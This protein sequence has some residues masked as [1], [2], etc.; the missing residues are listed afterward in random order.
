MFA[1]K[2][3]KVQS[4]ASES[5]ASKLAHQHSTIAARAFGG[6]AIEQAQIGNQ[7]SLRRSSQQGF[8]PTEKKVGGDH[9][10]E[11]T[12]A[13]MTAQVA[14]PGVSW[15]FSK[16][17]VFPPDRASRP[18]PSSPFAA[19]PLLG[20]T[21]ARLAVG[22]VNDP[23]EHEADR[24]ADQVMRMPAPDISVTSTPPNL[25]RK[26]TAGVVQD[27]LRSPG[28][29]LDTSTRAFF[30]PRF[31]HDFS[32]VRVHA[33]AKGA[34][35]AGDAG[36]RAYTLGERIVFGPSQFAPHNATGQHLLAHELAHVVQQR[37]AGAAWVQRAPL[38]YGNTAVTVQPPPKPFTLQDAKNLIQQ[39]MNTT[40]PALTKA[41]VKGATPGSDAEIFLWFIL[42]QVATPA[43]WGTENDLIE[44]IGWPPAPA[45]AT[46]GLPAPGGQGTTTTP[47][48]GGSA[49]TPAASAPV[50]AVTVR[51]DQAGA[52]VAELISTKP[53]GPAKTYAKP[54]DGKADLVAAYG[55]KSVADGDAAWTADELNRVAGAFAVL[56]AADKAAL[57]DVDLKRVQVIDA[58]HAAQF[59]DQT[60]AVT[61]T[62]TVASQ[63]NT[64][65]VGNAAFAGESTRFV[66]DASQPLPSSYQLLV[67]EVGHAIASKV[68]RDADLA[69]AQA[70]V[71][72]NLLVQPVTDAGAAVTAAAHELNGLIDAFNATIPKL[73]AAR[74]VKDD[75]TIKTILDDQSARRM[76]IDA[77]RKA[78]E[79]LRKDEQT[80]TA[81][82]TTAKA[83]QQK[84]KTA[85]AATRVSPQA[86]A[87]A[88]STATARGAAAKSALSRAQ[89]GVKQFNSQD[90]TDSD[91]FRSAVAAMS[92]QID[93]YVGN[94]NAGGVDAD[95]E[96]ASLSSATDARNQARD[97]L[98]AAA[99]A[100]PALAV[101]APVLTAQDA[102]AESVKTWARIAD[103]T[104]RVQRFVDMVNKNHIEPF[105][106][107][108]RDNWPFN[109]DEFYAEAYSLWRTDPEYLKANAK[110]VFDWFD[111]KNYLK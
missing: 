41:D 61:A 64:L 93:S 30:E 3:A 21:Q 110:P 20:A 38:T 50:A 82:L 37:S 76:V 1:P 59:G 10:Q 86:V 48:S 83:E 103:R 60:A 63:T 22:Q 40:P 6:G 42:A 29:P 44:P 9:E 107:Y 81:T 73:A 66:G 74:K 53:I 5:P 28:Q 104:M 19:T 75:A 100:N 12:P 80:K 99:A 45:S 25:R 67:H 14:T 102:W 58:T 39:R 96:D 16:I 70:I 78:L 95:T 97:S 65:S 88:K 2:V 111:N 47:Q 17:P 46:S 85:A 34:A 32:H 89:G 92:T 4:K 105:T 62:T 26:R 24:V 91:A 43:L 8:S 94:I 90:T 108:A 7:A 57:K 87:A 79:G 98:R 52:G 27:V 13:N 15:D 35:S 68:Q 31:G 51:I 54:E 49:P 56:P 11:G 33:D 69:N 106:Q 36:A 23:L 77:K 72:A 71:A 18:Q 109:P 84:T 55:L 101:F